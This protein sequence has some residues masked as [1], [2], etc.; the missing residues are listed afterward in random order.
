MLS[1]CL[2]IQCCLHC[3]WL[4]YSTTHTAHNTACLDY[5][6]TC[7]KRLNNFTLLQVTLTSIQFRNLIRLPIAYFTSP[8]PCTEHSPSETETHFGIHCKEPLC[9]TLTA[10]PS[11]HHSTTSTLH[12]QHWVSTDRPTR[13]QFFFF[14]F[15]CRSVDKSAHSSSCSKGST[16]TVLFRRIILKRSTVE[17]CSYFADLIHTQRIC[18]FFIAVTI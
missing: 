17:C 9:H 15:Y 3:H 4:P 7:N 13:P 6:T 5:S 14:L 8:S 12:T 2:V 1:H 16:V 11:I 18:C 10:P